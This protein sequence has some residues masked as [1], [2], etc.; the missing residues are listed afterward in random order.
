[1]SSPTPDPETLHATPVES[2][3]VD[4]RIHLAHGQMRSASSKPRF[5]PPFNPSVCDTF[6]KL[7]DVSAVLV[8]W[9]VFHKRPDCLHSAFRYHHGQIVYS[10]EVNVLM[11]APMLN[12]SSLGRLDDF[13][14]TW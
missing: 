7:K 8:P 9:R 10:D 6:S 2:A 12:P 3:A 1:M 14:Q 11:E 5:N 4:A 13:T